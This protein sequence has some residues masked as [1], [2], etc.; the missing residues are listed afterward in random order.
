[1]PALLNQDEFLARALNALPT[2]DWYEGRADS[3][4]YVGEPQR[5]AHT[6]VNFQ[7]LGLDD[8]GLPSEW[9]VKQAI[10]FSSLTAKQRSEQQKKWL[11]GFIGTFG[12]VRKYQPPPSHAPRGA[13]GKPVLRKAIARLALY[14]H[15]IRNQIGYSQARPIK[16][17]NPFIPPN[18]LDD[19]NWLWDSSGFITYLYRAATKG[20]VDPNGNGWSG[21]GYTGT[22]VANGNR[23]TVP[24]V[25]DII[26]FGQPSLPGGRAHAAVFVEPGLDG[27]IV[28]HGSTPGPLLTENDYRSDFHSVRR[29]I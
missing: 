26:F 3:E 23:V 19:G 21:Y 12:P 5:Q 4:D 14:F 24:K 7:G 28:G 16:G 10:R 1:M 13:P 27:R 15:L 8:D 22:L 11:D 17:V 20:K 25:G 29:Y 9:Q 6:A 2:N 18:R